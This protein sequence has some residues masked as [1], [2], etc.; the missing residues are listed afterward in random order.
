MN[1]TI[2]QANLDDLEA[3]LDWRMEVLH[4]V[5]SDYSSL[6]WEELRAENEV[7]YQ[8]EIPAGTHIACF[9]KIDE[10]IVG[11]GGVCMQTEMPS[12]DNY[13][14]ACA[15]LMNIY[16]RQAHRGKGIGQAIVQWLIDK[17]KQSGAQK[18]YLETSEAGR[19]LYQKMGFSDLKDY[20]KL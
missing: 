15:Y 19:K 20:M 10:E 2:V 3:L 7:Y 16:T 4:E 12:P 11:C 17:A 5:F 9:A 14:G 6:D 18:I 1:L 13:A 8:R